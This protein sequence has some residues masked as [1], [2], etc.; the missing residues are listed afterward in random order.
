MKWGH[1]SKEV[2]A[3]VDVTTKQASSKTSCP[4]K[5]FYSP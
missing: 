3:G 5:T 4:K 1:Q 2:T